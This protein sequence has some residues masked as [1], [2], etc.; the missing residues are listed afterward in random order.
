MHE[1]CLVL[2]PLGLAHGVSR[3]YRKKHRRLRR[4][5]ISHVLERFLLPSRRLL[6]RPKSAQE[7][8]ANS[9]CSAGHSPLPPTPVSRQIRRLP[10]LSA[11]WAF[12]F[13]DI[14]TG[15]CLPRW[16]LPSVPS[17]T[18]MPLPSLAPHP[19]PALS[20]RSKEANSLPAIIITTAPYIL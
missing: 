17:D 4:N 15:V 16:R 18:M 19:R 3:A 13:P 2:R 14:P 1:A 20:D 9:A 8:T 10:S 12:R 5:L 7:A 6:A 11:L